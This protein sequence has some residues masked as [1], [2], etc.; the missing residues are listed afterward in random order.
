V[1][2]VSRSRLCGS[3]SPFSGSFAAALQRVVVLASPAVRWSRS[4]ALLRLVSIGTRR[5]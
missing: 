3:R 1:A 2:D 5:G 4:A